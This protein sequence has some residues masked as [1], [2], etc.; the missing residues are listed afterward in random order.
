MTDPLAQDSELTDNDPLSVPHVDDVDQGDDQVDDVDDDAAAGDAPTIHGMRVDVT[1]NDGRQFTVYV[2][3][4]D[5]IA[6]DMTAPRRKWNAQTQPFLFGNFLAYSAAKRNELFGGTFDG[7]ESE[8][9]INSVADVTQHTA[10]PVPPT[11]PAVV[12]R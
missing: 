5:Y 4:R 6:W 1:M 7:R 9:W 3:N 12:Q 2:Q 8:S 11:R 10:A